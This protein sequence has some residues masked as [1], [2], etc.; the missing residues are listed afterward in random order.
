MYNISTMK[1]AVVKIGGKQYLVEEGCQLDVDKL[2]YQEGEKINFDQVLLLV[3]GD[4]IS[5]GQP[6]LKDIKVSAKIINHHKGR[7]I[8]VAKFKA[9]TGY[10][11]VRGFRPSFTSVLINKIS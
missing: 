7:K 8:R 1:Y 9:K 4:K 10:R 11:R 2:P 3:D 5:I 6:I